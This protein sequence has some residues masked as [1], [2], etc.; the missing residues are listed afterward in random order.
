MNERGIEDELVVVNALIQDDEAESLDKQFAT[1]QTRLARCYIEIC[2]LPQHVLAALRA[3][4]QLVVQRFGAKPAGDDDGK[5]QRFTKRFQRVDAQRL[6]VVLRLLRRSVVNPVLA[7]SGALG[8]LAERE[9][10]G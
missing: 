10:R 9:V 3:V 8:K 5:T 2:R 7:G 6:E 4:S 1:T